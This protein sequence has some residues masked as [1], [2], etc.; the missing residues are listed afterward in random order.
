[1]PPPSNFEVSS[2][3]RRFRVL[4]LLYVEF[5]GEE[6]SL[7]G[8]SGFWV[9]AGVFSTFF[10]SSFTSGLLTLSADA[11]SFVWMASLFCNGADLGF[12][13]VTAIWGSGS[14][15][16]A[17][18]SAVYSPSGLSLASVVALL[19]GFSELGLGP[20]VAGCGAGVGTV[21]LGTAVA[22]PL[23]S[24]ALLEVAATALG[25]LMERMVVLLCTEKGLGASRGLGPRGGLG[26]DTPA[27]WEASTE[28]S[29]SESLKEDKTGDVYR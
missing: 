14:D 4:A 10:F 20:E 17:L 2:M 25:A 29:I 5:V 23:G 18:E 26:L 15:F 16:P 7:P 11:L 12:S 6:T 13:A 28:H 3:D 19:G 9:T 22:F 1:M 8:S 21:G 24:A 27:I